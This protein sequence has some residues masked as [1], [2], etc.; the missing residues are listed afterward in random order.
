MSGAQQVFQKDFK[1]Y[2]ASPIAYI[3]ISIFLVLSGVFFFTSFFLTT[4]PR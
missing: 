2:F 3:V 4:R 1:V